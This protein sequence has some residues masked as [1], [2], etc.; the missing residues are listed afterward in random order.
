MYQICT[1]QTTNGKF[2]I[3]ELRYFTARARCG[4]LVS[5]KAVHRSQPFIA[6]QAARRALDTERA[7]MLGTASAAMGYHPAI[8]RKESDDRGDR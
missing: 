6:F 1:F 7:R 2:I 3:F 4:V 8:G 5:T